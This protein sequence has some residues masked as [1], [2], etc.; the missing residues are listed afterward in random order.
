MGRLALHL[1]DAPGV[2]LCAHPS[3]PSPLHH[4]VREE[5][6]VRRRDTCG[7]PW[8]LSRIY[9][10]DYHLRRRLSREVHCFLRV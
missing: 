7:L 9:E 3:H 8:V 6:I 1:F 2:Y 4:V 10:A 5:H